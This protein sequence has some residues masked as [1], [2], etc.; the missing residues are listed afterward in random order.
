[1]S[2]P[3][4]ADGKDGTQEWRLTE[5]VLSKQSWKSSMGLFFSMGIEQDNNPSL[6]KGRIL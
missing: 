1:M 6:S 4:V 2:H 3:Q 5:I